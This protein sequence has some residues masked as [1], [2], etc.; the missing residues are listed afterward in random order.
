MGCIF[1]NSQLTNILF[2]HPI[3][4]YY[5]IL[6]C[7]K[8]VIVLSLLSIKPYRFY[9]KKGCFTRVRVHARERTLFGAF[10][11]CFLFCVW[12]Y[13]F[14][15]TFPGCP[16]CVYAYVCMYACMRVCRCMC[17]WGV[18]VVVC[19]IVW[20]RIAI[21]ISFRGIWLKLEWCVR[22]MGTPFQ[23]SA[24]KFARKKSPAKK[25]W[26]LTLTPPWPTWYMSSR[27]WKRRCKTS[28]EIWGIRAP[29]FFIWQFVLGGVRWV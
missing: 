20:N 16:V 19:D 21:C 27:R 15:S 9:Q 8:K 3:F 24:K 26:G 14:L 7:E 12:L 28:D 4:S 2:C 23:N 17:V 29:D 1:W 18:V 5:F 11:F 6:S 13:A 25:S 10:T 22:G